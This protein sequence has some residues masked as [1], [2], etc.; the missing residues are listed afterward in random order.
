MPRDGFIMYEHI[1]FEKGAAN[2]K[3]AP[4]YATA[5]ALSAE[6]LVVG[7]SVKSNKRRVMQNGNN[8]MHT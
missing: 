1:P 8:E 4:A 6:R 5:Y 2:S 3:G 7:R